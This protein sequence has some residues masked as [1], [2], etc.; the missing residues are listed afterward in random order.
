KAE[1]AAADRK[2][3]AAQNT[4][5]FIKA[6]IAEVMTMT[7]MDKAKG[8][9]Y[10]FT[11]YVSEKSSVNQEELDR[12][13]LAIVTSAA[14]EAG[15]PDYVDVQLKTTTTALKEAD[16]TDLIEVATGDAVRFTKP[17]NAKE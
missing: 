14:R 6:K 12:L 10:S 4:L 1:K 17:R 5:D 8:S 7:G 15:L 16:A 11:K 2:V 3:K 13:Y 9:F